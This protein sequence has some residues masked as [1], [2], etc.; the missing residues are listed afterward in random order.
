MNS[1]DGRKIKLADL[2]NQ[3][4]GIDT[5]IPLLDGSKRRYVFLDNA[6]STPTFRSVLKCIEEFLPWYSGV[7]RGMGFKAVVATNVYDQTHRIAG[8][9]VGADLQRNVVLFGKN[10]TESVNL[11][12]RRF[13]F[14]TD[15]VV[16]STMMEHHSNDLPWRK[17]CKVIH[18]G[19]MEDG[20]VDLSV[21]KS[22]LQKHKGKVKLVAVS[23]ASNVTG[24]C[25]PIHE[26]AEWA[27]EVGA[28]IFVDAAQ[29]APHRPIDVLSNDDPRH[30]DFLAYSAHKIYAPFG[31]GVL[32]GPIEFF[33]K[34]DPDFVGGGTVSY[35]G[36]DDVEWAS[37]P[38]KDEAGSPNVVGAVALA[39]ALTI[40]NAVGME[41]I[42]EHETQLLEY[43]ISRMKNLPGI[44]I[45]G[46]T[47]NLGRKVGVIPFTVG[48]M[49]HAL[50]ATILSME[51]GI[52]VRNG[53]FC[54]QVY[55][56]KLLNVSPEEEKMKRAAR[57]DNPILPGMVRASFGCYNNEEDVDMFIEMLDR[58]VRK[59]FRGTY[60]I[61][62][63]TGMYSM[64]GYTVDASAH[65]RF[66]DPHKPTTTGEEV[67]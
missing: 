26:I 22:E 57:C 31:I 16:I 20:G 10:T 35:V 21:L 50:V 37:P 43:A 45:Y 17:Y 23:G 42:T 34:G 33:A 49:D 44:R 56:R 13:N 58:I 9:F 61:D 6:A 51:G 39:E 1:N 12:A 28:K 48:G 63:I 19:I 41:T 24:I 46:P 3:V 7:H 52:G 11:L 27:H 14:A 8:E 66:F 47:E 60:A 30:I 36:L 15:D 32:V 38:Q 59:Q 65:F 5:T 2:R 18:V 4:V 29:L 64:N 40:L 53:N 54:A 62:P 55:M 67:A 25:N